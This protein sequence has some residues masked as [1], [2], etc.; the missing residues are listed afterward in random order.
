MSFLRWVSPLKMDELMLS[1]ATRAVLLEFLNEKNNQINIT[2]YSDM[3]GFREDWQLS[4]FWYKV[5]TAKDLAKEAH[6]V[7]SV[8]VVGFVSSP[9][10]FVQYKVLYPN[11]KCTLFE[12]DDRFNCFKEFVYFDY[13][14]PEAIDGYYKSKYDCLVIDPP[15]LSEEC[16]AKTMKFVEFIAAENCKFIICTGKVMEDFIKKHGCQ[17]VDYHPCHEKGLSNDFGCFLNY[18]SDCRKFQY[19]FK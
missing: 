11:S 8:S 16:F 5:D 1:D 17:L 9:S 15:F 18:K 12:F 10:A 7:G 3:S 2:E 6:C 14:H 4:Q 13:K 19:K